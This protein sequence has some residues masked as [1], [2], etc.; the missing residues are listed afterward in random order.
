M[1]TLL[2]K[3]E[4][5]EV[6]VTEKGLDCY[7][8]SEVVRL[9]QAVLDRAAVNGPARS[10]ALR[11]FKDRSEAAGVEWKGSVPDSVGAHASDVPSVVA[12][13][14]MHLLAGAGGTKLPD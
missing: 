6:I 3:A 1:R 4:I 8:D 9:Y 5:N 10:T 7:Q 12:H 11:F 13:L 2:A 14:Y